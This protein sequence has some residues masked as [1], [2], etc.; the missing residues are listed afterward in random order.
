MT[1]QPPE[2]HWKKP[3]GILTDG[4]NQAPTPTEEVLTIRSLLYSTNI[5]VPTI[6]EWNGH[7]ARFLLISDE[8]IGSDIKRALAMLIQVSDYNE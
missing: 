4:Y 8:G 7:V 1:V 6:L 3:I 5:I 2:R